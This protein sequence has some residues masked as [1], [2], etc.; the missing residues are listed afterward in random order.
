[1]TSVTT[2]GTKSVKT[3][4]VNKMSNVDNK[5]KSAKHVALP[6]QYTDTGNASFFANLCGQDIRYSHTSRKWFIW[7]GKRWA[8]DKTGAIYRKAKGAVRKMLKMASKVADDD[9]RRALVKHALKSQDESRL[10]AMLRLAESEPGIPVTE[11]QLDSDLWLLNVEN[12]TLDLR[13]GELRP[14]RQE[15]LI[16]K[17][18]PVSYDPDAT[19][20]T[21]DAFLQRIMDGS[22]DLIRFLQ[23]AIG[24][25]LTGSTKEQVIF[26]L[27][28]TGANGKS[29]FLITI[30]SLLGDYARQTPTETLLTKSGNTIPN[31]VA[32]LKGARFVDA[33]EAENGKKLAEALVKRLT[34]GD[35]ITARFLYGEFFEFDPTFN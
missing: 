32:R 33:A 35:K 16:T 28:G 29:T 20:P 31:D 9:K 23:K 26:I 34:G 19:C 22:E 25:S 1:M 17:L 2:V 27:Y 13:T 5:Y 4:E 10:K 3:T 14:H 6:A 8:V 12:G 11:V 7:D 15:D 24:Y 18:I 30:H 21:W